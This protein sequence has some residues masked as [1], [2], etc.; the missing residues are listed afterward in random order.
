[1]KTEHD[2]LILEAMS[3]YGGS[4]VQQLA[5]LAHLADTTNFQKLKST[6]SNYWEEY[7][8]FLKK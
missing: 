3:K 8:N 2:Y 4:F 6:F 5:K 7:E 1:M